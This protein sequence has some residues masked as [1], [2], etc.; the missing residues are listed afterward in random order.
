MSSSDGGRRTPRRFLGR[1][2]LFAFIAALALSA[3][4]VQ[5]LYGP[6]ATN[7]SVA[8]TLT[9][10]TIDPIN[11]RVGQVVRNKLIFDLTGGAG[12]SNAIY[13]M[14]LNVTSSETALGVTTIE[15]A[16]SYS[17]TVAVTYEVTRMATGEVVLHGTARA[18]GGY[19]RVNQI[20]AN[21]RAKQDA[22]DR[23]ATVA[24]DQIRLLVAA[25]AAKGFP[26]PSI[27][28]ATPSGSD[29]AAR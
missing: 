19:D 7:G 14:H 1:A 12:I 3:C 23:A 25:A 6:T 18:Q 28:T 2:G 17:V 27:A 15:A 9:Q 22:E 16:P 5:P 4:T 13:H 21:I 11:D 24:A 10:I 8:T 29:K 20:F 26:A